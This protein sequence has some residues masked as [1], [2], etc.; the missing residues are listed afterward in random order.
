[1]TNF[2]F[3]SQK[4]STYKK[5]VNK[6]EIIQ[7]ELRHQRVEHA[8]ILL[9]LDKLIVDKHLQTQVDQYFKD[10]EDGPAD[11]ESL[12]NEDLD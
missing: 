8:K 12:K 2:I 1:M 7:T 10:T 11:M 9:L 3:K 5:L 6:L 4:T